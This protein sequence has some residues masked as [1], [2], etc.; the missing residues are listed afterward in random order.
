M[1]LILSGEFFVAYFSRGQYISVDTCVCQQLVVGR[2]RP[3]P[4]P[5]H[6]TF[7]LHSSSPPVTF[8]TL[9]ILT[10]YSTLRSHSGLNICTLGPEHPLSFAT[11]S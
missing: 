2:V 3:E 8:Y 10:L 6:F 5:G 1:K 9:H 11:L 7:Q 4:L